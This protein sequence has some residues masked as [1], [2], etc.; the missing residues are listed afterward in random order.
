MIRKAFEGMNPWL[1]AVFF[2]SMILTGMAVAVFLGMVTV[3]GANGWSLVEATET[4]SKPGTA[5]GFWTNMTV[6]SMNQL[7]AFGGMA[8]AFGWLFGRARLDGMG[9]QRPR[10]N[11]WIWMLLAAVGTHCSAPILDGTYR[12]NVWLL[13]WLPTGLRSLA[14]QYEAV[15]AET[16]EAL[17]TFP[18]GAATAAV[19]LA[20]AVLPSICEEFA[21]RGVFQPLFTRGTGRLHLGIWLGAAVFSAIHMQFHGFLPRMFIGAGLGYIVVWSGSIWPAIT[22]HFVNNMGTVVQAKVMG[23][24]WVANEM[25]S[26]A[27]WEGQDYLLA[28]ACIVGLGTCYWAMS[29]LAPWHEQVAR[30]QASV[31]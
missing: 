27:P 5:E 22:G 12:L 30:Y 31:R 18:G 28:A 15:A 14:D 17:L 4:A 20:V 26:T 1:Q 13:E 3:M 29:K 6:N 16:T 24:E 11:A 9:T 19:V 7:I 25:Q 2:A 21:F 23:A 8:W 10:G